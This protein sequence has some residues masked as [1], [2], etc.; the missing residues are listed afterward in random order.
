MIYVVG[1]GPAG[2]SCAM[3]LIKKG[4]PVTMLDAGIELEPERQQVLQRLASRRRE[5]WD[6]DALHMIKGRTSASISGIPIKYVY[7]SDFPYREAD[8]FIP[9]ESKKAVASPSLAKGG[10]SN[11]WGATCLPYLAADIADWPISVSELAPHYEAVLSFMSLSATRDNLEAAFPLYSTRYRPLR[12]G[13]QAAALLQDLHARQSA[14]NAAGILFGQSRLAVRAEADDD[15]PGCVYCGLCMYG[16]PYGLIYNSATTLAQLQRESNF[17]YVKDVVVQKVTEE[18]GQVRIFAMSRL[19]RENLVFEGTRA[20]L[21]CGVWST[22]KILLESLEA[23]DR[24]VLMKDSQ[25]FLFPLLRYR[26]AP[27]VQHEDLYTLAQAFLDITDPQLD[28]NTVHLE[29][30]T[31]NDLYLRAIRGILGPTYPLLRFPVA[32]FLG[33]LLIVQGFL[34]SHVSA[35]ISV[36]LLQ[37]KD[38]S[39]ARLALEVNPNPRT[40]RVIQGVLAK[41]F[42]NRRYLKAV[43]LP[44]PLHIAEP[45]R[46]FH[47]GGTFPMRSAPGEYESDPLGRPHGFERVHVVD[48]TTFPSI[49]ATTITLSIMANAHR[50]A[51]AYDET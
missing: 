34:H 15:G 21:A 32:E 13:R 30:C 25:Y 3:A 1:S 40:G 22:T 31:Y 46:S 38:G 51:S 9:I 24:P 11:A 44:V 37:G 5:E 19:N 41:L 12:P 6:A 8:L 33:R 47:S 43:P 20:Y 16:C 26:K 2:V 35:T 50:I 39:P 48:A 27:D 28:G 29:L 7:G 49:P 36:R 42:A 45:G 23:Y 14:L 18:K 17:R 10:F 4:L